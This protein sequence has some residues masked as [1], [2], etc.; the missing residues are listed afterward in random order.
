MENQPIPVMLYYSRVIITMFLGFSSPS[1]CLCFS[2]VQNW[3]GLAPGTWWKTTCWGWCCT[4]WLP[5]GVDV[6]Y[7]VW[8][9]G[10]WGWTCGWKDAPWLEGWNGGTAAAVAGH[11]WF[12][13]PAGRFSSFFSDL[14]PS[15]LWYFCSN[16][17]IFFNKKASICLVWLS[18]I[19]FWLLLAW[20][21]CWPE[22]DRFLDSDPSSPAGCL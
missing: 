21:S 13:H 11:L 15:V 9:G 5:L 6:V 3:Y 1:S 16:S 18:S 22:R 12:I 19:I 20:S 10:T 2:V 17:I 8:N 4:H 14:F 7:G